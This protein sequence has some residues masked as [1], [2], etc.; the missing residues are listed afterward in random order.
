[1]SEII[2]SITETFVI[3]IDLNLEHVI[4]NDI[5]VYDISKVVIQIAFVADEFF[6]IWKNQGVIV[7]IFKKKK[8][9][10]LFKQTLHLNLFEFT[11]SIKRTK[12]LLIKRLTNFISKVKYNKLINLRFIIIQYSWYKDNYLMIFEK[13]ELS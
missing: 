2:I 11:L 3:Q 5:I 8:C 6:K 4:S 9:S 13:I 10:Y 1:M 12:T 7:N